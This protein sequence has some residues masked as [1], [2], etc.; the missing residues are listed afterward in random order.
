MTLPMTKVVTMKP[1]LVATII[2]KGWPIS[3]RTPPTRTRKNFVLPWWRWFWSRWWLW[4]QS[5]P[6]WSQ[7]EHLWVKSPTTE[8]FL[9][10]SRIALLFS[11]TTE[12]K[13]YEKQ[14]TRNINWQRLQR[15]I[16]FGRKIH[17]I[18]TKKKTL[19]LMRNS[20][21]N[22]IPSVRTSLPQK[23]QQA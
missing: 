20:N 1:T 5:Q 15:Q 4:W 2:T 7:F 8:W 16:D 23:P 9:Q 18:G 11:H 6:P 22:I 21:S 13:K 12:I 17:P 14:R 10:V 3:M 19:I